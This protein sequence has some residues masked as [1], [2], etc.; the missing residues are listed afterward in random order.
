M[1][2]KRGWMQK[3]E[4][5]ESGLPIYY[6]AGKGRWTKKPYTIAVLLTRTRC[7]QLGVPAMS[8]DSESPSALLY[9][10]L[11][12]SKVD[13]RYRYVPLYDRTEAYPLI[14]NQLNPSEIMESPDNDVLLF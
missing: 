12:G 11:S 14:K 6:P 5:E 4:A 1:P 7:Q 3:K 13:D 8:P 9:K 10:A 2:D